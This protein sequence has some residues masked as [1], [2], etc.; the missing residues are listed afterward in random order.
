MINNEWER[1]GE[2]I[3][4]TIQNAVDSRNFSR[5][6]QTVSD[7]IGQAM[8]NISRGLN[9]GGWYRRPGAPGQS[10]PAGGPE[11]Q[12]QNQPGQNPGGPADGGGYGSDYGTGKAAAG[13][14]G[15]SLY[16]KGTSARIGGAFLAVTGGV[17]GIVSIAFLLFL[18]F[19]SIAAGWS[20]LNIAGS[21]A[22]GIFTIAFAVMFGAGLGMTSEAGRFRRYVKILQNREYCDVKELAARTGRSVRAVVK[23]LKRMIKKGWFRQGHLDEQETCLMVSDNAY[24]Q[25]TGLMERMR[26]EKAEKARR[27]CQSEAGD[28]DCLR[29]FRRLWLQD[30]ELCQ[31]NP[32]GQRCH[33]RAR[34]YPRRSPEWRCWWPDF[35]RVEQNPASVD[36]IGKLMEYYLPTTIKL[37]EAYED[38][39][40]QPVQGE[41]I[42]S[43]KRE[44]EKTIDTLNTAF[45]K[46]LD[47]LFQDTSW[48][49]SS[50]ISV[51]QMMLAQDGL[52]ED[53]LKKK[54]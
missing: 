54:P 52:T 24:R 41:N 6:N 32:A 46:L 48:D 33:I 31:E 34:R 9:N 36:D 23:D 16:L 15:S 11:Y 18:V 14:S 17:F 10:G 40:A 43:S 50:D 8:D 29:R 13:N 37:L 12:T 7:T 44:I 1:F 21:A 51:L 39:D 3:R 4:R 25:Y 19:T 35:D 42:L 45:E 49:V 20:V 22:I 53:G 5:L 26:R 28:E 2:D 30:G 47:D 27:R 38:L